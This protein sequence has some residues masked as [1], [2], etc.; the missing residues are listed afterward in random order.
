MR[1]I[2]STVT[3]VA[4]AAGIVLAQTSTPKTAQAVKP[5][6]PDKAVKGSGKLPPEWK[7]RFDQPTAKIDAVSFEN[8]GTGFHITSGPAAIYYMPR[9]TSGK[10]K[11]QATFT[12]VAAS[13]HPE[14][15]GLFIGGS[16]LDGENQK[17]TYFVIN[18]TGKF[19]IKRR[20]GAETPTL[21][22][23][24][25]STAIKK[26]DASGKMTNALT[27]DVAADKVHFLINNTVVASQPVAQVD[28]KGLTGIRVNHNLDVI[29][30]ALMLSADAASGSP[31]H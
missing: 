14:A 13:A 21:M 17:Y 15:Y 24:A 9:V 26:A 19:L 25:D 11:T 8:T 30:E 20:A 16:D 23:W 3:F 28:T 1:R 2:L 31:K 12:Q 27:I 29:V 6:D 7:V 22:N 4:L 18:Q 5:S 10:Y